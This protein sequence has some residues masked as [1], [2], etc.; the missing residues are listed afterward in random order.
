MLAE[1]RR[2]SGL[3]PRCGFQTYDRTCCVVCRQ[4]SRE[5][6]K[7]RYSAARG[8]IITI[9]GSLC[10]VCGNTDRETLQIDHVLSDGKQERQM[11][12]K[13]RYMYEQM[14]LRIKN[15]QGGRYQLLCSSCHR[16]KTR[17][18]LRAA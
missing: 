4:N 6:N 10:F 16:Q 11:Y 3:C 5:I 8:K 9:L 17:E 2:R 14:L 18:V 12:G 15:G 13:G 7:R 1:K